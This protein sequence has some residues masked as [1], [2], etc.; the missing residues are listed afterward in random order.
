MSSPSLIVGAVGLRPVPDGASVGES[1]PARFP[2]QEPPDGFGEQAAQAAVALAIDVAEELGHH[3][4][5]CF[6]SGRSR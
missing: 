6:R 1:L 4:R 3:R 2:A 5:C